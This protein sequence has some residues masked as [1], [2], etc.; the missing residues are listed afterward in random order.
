[1]YISIYQSGNFVAEREVKVIPRVGE[2]ITV[3]AEDAITINL[4]YKREV[5]SIVHF[6]GPTSS[7]IA[8]HV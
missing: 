2:L 5:T 1:M 3:C 8:V 4:I 7:I 6:I